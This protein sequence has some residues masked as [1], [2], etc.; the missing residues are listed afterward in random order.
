VLERKCLERV[1]AEFPGVVL[2][3]GGGIVAETPTYELLL[4]SF[5]TIWLKARP[6]IMFERVLS[7]HD[8]RIAS[9]EL[10]K[11]AI[12]NITRTLD[13]RQHLYELAAVSFDTGGKTPDQIASALSVLI[14]STPQVRYAA[15]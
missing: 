15:R 8:A 7:Q 10:R 14:P 3:T 9:T 4:T 13:A 6:Q 1:I 5:F 2:A 11:E 12:E